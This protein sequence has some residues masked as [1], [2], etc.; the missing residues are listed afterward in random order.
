MSNTKPKML[1]QSG[2]YILD[3]LNPDAPSKEQWIMV[4]NRLRGKDEPWGLDTAY[5]VTELGAK[6]AM[7]R[8]LD[9]METYATRWPMLECRLQGGEW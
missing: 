7:Q 4:M 6:E 1:D 5:S 9:K 8:A 2:T 3:E